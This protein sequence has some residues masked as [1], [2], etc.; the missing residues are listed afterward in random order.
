MRHM[1]TDATFGSSIT[2]LMTSLAVVFILLLV[3]YLNRTYADI[4]KSRI[5]VKQRLINALKEHEIKATPD[6]KDPL[7][8]LIEIGNKKINFAFDEAVLTDAGKSYVKQFM[9]KLSGILTS[10]K[11]KKDVESVLIEGHTDQHG[12]DEHNVGLSQQRA[13]A[14]LSCTLNETDLTDTQ[15]DALL[16]LVSTNGRG[17][18]DLPPKEASMSGDAY[19]ESCRR[20]IFK[21]RVKS[22]EQK[23]ELQATLDTGSTPTG[24]P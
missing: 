10:E 13:L 11:F 15:K 9:P 19:D 1:G 2:D 4:H 24:A 17:K 6:P 5:D 18:R 21:I 16:N 12:T 8:L 14:V 22:Y 7:S 3:A 20:V 23:R